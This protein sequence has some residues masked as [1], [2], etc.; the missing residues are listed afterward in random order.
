MDAIR[1]RR[2]ILAV[3]IIIFL[4]ALPAVIQYGKY[5]NYSTSTSGLA[6]SESARAQNALNKVSPQNQTLLLVVNTT[7]INQSAS[8]LTLSF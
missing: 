2:I 7:H 1:H 3:W 4:A 5:I 8:N 6:N